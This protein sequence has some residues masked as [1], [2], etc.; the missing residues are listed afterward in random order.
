MSVGSSI[1]TSLGLCLTSHDSYGNKI[2]YKNVDLT[3]DFRKINI[4][5]LFGRHCGPHSSSIKLSILNSHDRL[6][7]VGVRKK[8]AYILV[9]G[10]LP[11]QHSF[12]TNRFK[13]NGPVPA[14]SRQ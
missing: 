10:D 3:Q 6:S 1:S 7:I 11:R 14:D 9:H 8:G 13:V 2:L 5:A 12:R 4:S